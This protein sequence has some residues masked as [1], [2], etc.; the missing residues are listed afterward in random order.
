[1]L[2]KFPNE[3][4]LPSTTSFYFKQYGFCEEQAFRYLLPKG[5]F[6]YKSPRDIS[7]IPAQYFNQ[8]LLNFNQYF[9]SDADYIFLLGLYT[10]CTICV[11]HETLLYLKLKQ[12]GLQQ[13]QLKVILKEQLKGL[14]QETMYFHL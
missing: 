13:K 11:H 3:S 12:L 9:A 2:L 1:M 4:Q 5:K 8:R 10:S 7:I 6:G 14:L